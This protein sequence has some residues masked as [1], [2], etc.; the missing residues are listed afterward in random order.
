MVAKTLISDRALRVS[1]PEFGRLGLRRVRV[2]I[3][4]SRGAGRIEHPF[5]NRATISILVSSE[6]D[7]RH[8][9]D[10]SVHRKRV[11]A[12]GTS[13]VRDRKSHQSAHVL[14]TPLLA[15]D[16]GFCVSGARA[17]EYPIHQLLYVV[18]SPL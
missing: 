4:Q 12:H 13:C 18:I 17:T 1:G 8:S 11:T 6:R 10:E 2:G 9:G 7:H 5:S 14:A 3:E 15:R 16:H